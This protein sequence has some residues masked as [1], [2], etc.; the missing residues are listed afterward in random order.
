M[1]RILASLA[2]ACL[3]AASAKAQ[4]DRG[5]PVILLVHGRGMTG[6]DT[7]ATRKLWVN[8]LTQ[9]ATA[10]TKSPVI[11]ERD[12]RVVWYAD[13]LDPRSTD[14]CDYAST[15][16]RAR[17]DAKVDPG[18]RQFTQ[19]AGGLLSLISAVTSDSGDAAQ[20][21]ALASDA[22]FL[23]DAR[24]RCASEARLASAIERA[25]GEGR[26]IV[27]VAHSLGSLVAYDYLSA[28]ADTGVIQRFVTI[29][30]M[31]GAPDLRRLLIGGDSTDAFTVPSSVKEWVNIRNDGD[32]FATPLPIGRDIVETPPSDEPDPHEMVGYLRT[33]TTAREILGAWCAAFPNSRLQGCKDIIPK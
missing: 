6:R 7:A 16:P 19:V 3:L 32:L 28:R 26:P 5:R 11:D 12:I 30:S 25:R 22:S 15:D 10:L 2:C 31:A 9:G 14:G 13:V 8:G 21:R 18:F 20:V 1:K 29:G 24:K 27:L 23:G 4:T 33:T 17:R